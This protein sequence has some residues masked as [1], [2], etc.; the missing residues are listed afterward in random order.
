[1]GD[2]AA[3]GRCADAGRGKGKPMLATIVILAMMVAI[4][5]GLIRLAGR[6]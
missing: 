3:T 5:I 4:I 2:H 6:S 1:M